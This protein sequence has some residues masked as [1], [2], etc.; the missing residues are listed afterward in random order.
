MKNLQS[1]F[2]HTSNKVQNIVNNFQKVHSDLQTLKSEY[3][4]QLELNGTGTT[5]GTQSGIP[6]QLSEE[7]I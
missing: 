7:E 1:K 2:S 3:V 4:Q 5:N 6:E